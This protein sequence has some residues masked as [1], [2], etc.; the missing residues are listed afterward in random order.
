MS[1][2]VDQGTMAPVE[3]LHLRW[4]GLPYRD[5]EGAFEAMAADQISTFGAVR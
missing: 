2:A 3:S 5:G 4:M 1:A